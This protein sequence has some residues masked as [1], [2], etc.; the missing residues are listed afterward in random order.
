[1]MALA[2]TNA[3][4]LKPDVK[5]N[6]AL[7]DYEKV[8]FDN[9]RVQLR[10]EGAPD[11]MAAIAFTAVI[12]KECTKG[13][14][15]CMGP[16]LITFLESVQQFSGVIDTFVSSNPQFAALVWGGVKLTLRV[17]S[18]RLI[19]RLYLIVIDRKQLLVLF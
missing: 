19:S 12:D 8:L 11:T 2:S 15:R 9:E 16:R 17:I 14:R 7:V 4:P 10:A 6:Q 3:A 13:R 1:M 5:L 18:P